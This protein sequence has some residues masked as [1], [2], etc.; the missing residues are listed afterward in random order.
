M[1]LNSRTSNYEMTC[2]TH[3]T[4]ASR[5]P[6]EQPAQSERKSSVN[7]SSMNDGDDFAPDK[8]RGHT[9]QNC[10]EFISD[11]DPDNTTNIHSIKPDNLHGEDKGGGEREHTPHMGNYTE[12]IEEMDIGNTTIA[13]GNADTGATKP[14]FTASCT[15]RKL[16]KGYLKAVKEIQ[17]H[18]GGP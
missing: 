2:K 6:T 17:K 13:S 15:L 18:I 10:A 4:T 5:R 12:F 3:R 1:V 14:W 11:G 8:P 16:I 7:G 9:N